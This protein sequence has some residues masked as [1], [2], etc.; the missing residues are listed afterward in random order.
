MLCGSVLRGDQHRF[1]LLTKQQCGG[2]AKG[3]A[4]IKAAVI[5]FFQQVMHIMH[6]RSTD[7]CF[8]A[9]RGAYDQEQSKSRVGVR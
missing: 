1:A 3:N 4:R 7:G 8:I 5:M 2:K 6:D 9:V